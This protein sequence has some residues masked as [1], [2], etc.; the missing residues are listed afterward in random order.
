[1]KTIVSNGIGGFFPL[2]FLCP[3]QIVEITLGKR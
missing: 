2:R 1:M 3:P